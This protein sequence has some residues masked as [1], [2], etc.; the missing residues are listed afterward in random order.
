MRYALAVLCAVCFFSLDAF[1]QIG[2]TQP[3]LLTPA[4]AIAPAAPAKPAPSPPPPE[5]FGSYAWQANVSLAYV[6]FREGPGL[7]PNMPGFSTS[8]AHYFYFRKQFGVEGEMVGGFARQFGQEARFVFVGV[9]A[10]YRFPLA[11]K[12]E[13]WAHFVIGHAH[14]R[15]PSPFG[16]QGAFGFEPGGGVDYRMNKWL[17]V[18]IEGDV[19]TTF[20]FSKA[21]ANPKIAGGIVF[22][23]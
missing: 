21:Q 3:L 13:P 9:G 4:P 23:F 10:R 1:A 11:G 18:R 2:S 6:K 19:I 20:F 16:K 7:S 15:P 12:W 22:N 8:L 17:A 5:L 14:Q